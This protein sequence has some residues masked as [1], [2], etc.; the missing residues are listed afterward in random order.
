MMNDELNSPEQEPA[1]SESEMDSQ[2]VAAE[3]AKSQPDSESPM[4]GD[5]QPVNEAPTGHEDS[6][7]V[8]AETGE[9]TGPGTHC[10]SCNSTNLSYAES[11]EHAT[12]P[13]CGWGGP[14]TE[15]VHG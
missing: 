1:V 5:E 9:P 10:P 13:F 3:V 7:D 6:G 12:C 14:T 8:T 15:L 11:G 2:P 4:F